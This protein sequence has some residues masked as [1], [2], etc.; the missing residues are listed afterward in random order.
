[1]HGVE[2]RGADSGGERGDARCL[3]NVGCSFANAGGIAPY[4]PIA[5]KVRDVGRK[6]VIRLAAEEASTAR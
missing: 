1:M 3:V 2:G 4:A 5:S 6:V